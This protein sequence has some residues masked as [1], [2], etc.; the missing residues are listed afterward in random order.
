MMKK[1]FA[2]LFL[3]PFFTASASAA[4]QG[5]Y[6]GANIGQ[7][8]TDT[9]T[10]NTKTAT[11]YSLI[12]GYQFLKYLAAEIE[13]NDFGSPTIGPGYGPA[14]PAGS[15]DR[16]D[17]YSIKAVGI[18]P[19]TDQ[20]SVFAKLGYANV[21]WGGAVN[22]SKSD[23]TYG[24]GGQFN[25]DRHWGVNLNYDWYKVAGPL[26]AVGGRQNATVSEPSIGVQYK[27]Y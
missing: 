11:G 14:V 2:A 13:W 26:Q 22:S 9:I 25:I 8:S 15:S 5:F 1:A 27:F 17:G 21:R 6:I 12:A 20:W 16:I 10:M 7:S 19:F 24:I 23:L 18:Y 3:L 4:D